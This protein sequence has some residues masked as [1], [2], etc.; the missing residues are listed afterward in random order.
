MKMYAYITDP[1][2]F[3]AG[4][5]SMH[6]VDHELTIEDWVLA[7]EV[8]IDIDVD[9]HQIKEMAVKQIDEEEAELRSRFQVMLDGLDDKRQRILSIAHQPDEAA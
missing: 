2:A 9:A 5:T 4:S 8:D 1:A 7:G 6:L 3:A